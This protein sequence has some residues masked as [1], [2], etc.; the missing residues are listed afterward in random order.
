[1]TKTLGISKHQGA[2]TP[3]TA[4][5]AGVKAVIPRPACGI[6]PPAACRLPEAGREDPSGVHFVGAL[7]GAF[8]R[9]AL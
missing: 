2:F 5:V 1:M 7:A 9:Q 6:L 3:G 8:R 4:K